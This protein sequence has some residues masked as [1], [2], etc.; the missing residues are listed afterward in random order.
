MV[1]L[2]EKH[3]SYLANVDSAVARESFEYHASEHLRL[4]G[5]Y[6]GYSAAMLLGS[7]HEVMPSPEEIE[8][9]VW[10]CFDEATGG[11]G[12]QAGHDAHITHTLSGIQLLV[13]VG[14]TDRLL[15]TLN[16]DRLVS[17]IAKL[18]Q[19]DGSVAGDMFGEVDTRFVLC[20]FLAL[21]LLNRLDAI[22]VEKSL[23]WLSS[24]KNF[25]AGY[26]A[27]P[28]AE[29]HAAQIWTV[30]ASFALVD[31]CGVVRN[32]SD[33][34]F[35]SHAN[36]LGWWLAERQNRSDGGLNGRPEKS[37]DVCYSWWVL[38]SLEILG[39][40]DWISRE[41]LESFI[42]SCQDAESGGI[43]DAPGNYPDVW[44][45]FFGIA[46][47]SLLRCSRD[48]ILTM[49]ECRSAPAAF[50]RGLQQIID[51][52]YAMPV[53]VLIRHFGSE[54]NLWFDSRP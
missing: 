10:S 1:I 33:A 28:G 45:T 17:F 26:G 34:S 35:L 2:R 54:Y 25:D 41:A 50:D 20:A 49:F 29:S 21:K 6:W 11:F 39:K 19:L 42:E 38:A 16:R 53:S 12:G 8:K 22:D 23:R 37:S 51:P 7:E 44:H 27:V 24:C 15:E 14:K 52:R 4:S 30:V 36:S 47:L 40:T 46:G 13:L 9:F 3:N 5:V 31:R 18:Q 43:A 32:G 48:D